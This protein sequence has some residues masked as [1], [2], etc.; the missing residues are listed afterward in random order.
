[1]RKDLPPEEK[2]LRLIRGQDKK[3]KKPI[4]AP[5]SPIVDKTA[6]VP[7]LSAETKPDISGQA[8]AGSKNYFFN[9][10]NFLLVIIFIGV[11]AYL[12]WE[13]FKLKEE[14]NLSVASE[15]AEVSLPQEQ[16]KTEEEPLKPYSYYSQEI[17]KKELFKASVLQGQEK[18]L[19]SSAP[20][21]R[22]LSADL[23]LLGI[24]L[25][26]QPQAII[27]DKKAKK[28]YFLYKGDVIGE[29]KVDEIMEGKVILSY[30][31]EKIELVP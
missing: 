18:E 7:Q 4:S 28:S 31:G 16:L 14:S 19:T 24:V 9:L 27:E 13:I 30:Q 17:G 8:E 10:F 21:I 25:D 11:I 2:L 20:T 12:G 26:N 15:I 22:D 3:E 5:N 29:M 6:S 23:I 1:M